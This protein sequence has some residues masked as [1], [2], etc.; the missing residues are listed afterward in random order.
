MSRRRKNDRFYINGNLHVILHVSRGKDLVTAFDYR[1]G[2][3]KIYPWSEIK[4]K[5][6]NAFTITEA[7]KLVG[8]HRDRIVE[9]MDKGKIEKPQRE[10]GLENKKPWRYFFSEDD[11]MD[12]RDAMAEI[13]HGRPRKDG[14]VT[15][16][17]LPTRDEMKAMITSKRM[18]YVQEEGEFK[19]IWT[20]RS[21]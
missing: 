19:P 9:Y 21:F 4:K 15:N 10:Y 17:R 16:N 5:A 8:R 2:K 20:E 1:E 13:H 18:I 14:K 6:Q 7:A 12:L 11:M 3:K